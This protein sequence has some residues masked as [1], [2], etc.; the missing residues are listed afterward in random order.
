M[1]FFIFIIFLTVPTVLSVAQTKFVSEEDYRKVELGMTFEDAE[2]IFGVQGILDTTLIYIW[3]D[4]NLQVE[5]VEGK[6][7]SYSTSSTML[8]DGEI[9]GYETLKEACAGPEGPMSYSKTYEEVVKLI[10]KEGQKPDWDRYLWWVN[11]YKKIKIVFQDG[12]VKSK[13]MF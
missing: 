2:N 12:K 5:W 7:N 8:K 4:N 3:P 9:N 13:E 11:K 1:K 10:G 6:I